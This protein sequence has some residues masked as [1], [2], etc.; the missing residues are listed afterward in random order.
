MR[1]EIRVN[2]SCQVT[3]NIGLKVG[4]TGL[5]MG[6]ITRASNRIDYSGPNLISITPDGIHQTFFANGLNFGVEINR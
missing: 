2:V 5:V 1:G 6:N 3:G 4:Y